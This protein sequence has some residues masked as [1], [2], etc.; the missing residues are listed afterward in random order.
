MQNY[1]LHTS[2]GYQPINI[3]TIHERGYRKNNFNLKRNIIQG[4]NEKSQIIHNF[5]EFHITKTQSPLTT[6]LSNIS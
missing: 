2:G 5:R 1:Y 3:M 4:Q 6:N